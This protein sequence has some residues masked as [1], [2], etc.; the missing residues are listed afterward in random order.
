MKQFQGQAN[1]LF[2][3]LVEKVLLNPDGRLWAGDCL[4]YSF[5]QGNQET[6]ISFG[7]YSNERMPEDGD[8]ILLEPSGQGTILFEKE[9]S[10]NVLFLTERCNSRCLICPQPPREDKENLID[11]N[12]RILSLIDE[13]TKVMGITGGEPT[14]VWE[15]LMKILLTCKDDLPDTEIQL[16]T[17]GRILKS[18]EK[19]EELKANIGQAFI[20]GIPLY[21]DV[22]SLHDEQTG[23][24]GSFWDT[25]EGIFNLERLEIS[26]EIRTVINRLNYFRLSQWAEFIYRTSPFARHIA[27]MGLEPI[28]YA[29]ENL[30]KIWVDPVEYSRE[31]EKAVRFLDRRGMEV[32][33]YNHQLCTLPESLWPFC[34]KS[35]SGWKTI[36]LP[37]CGECQLKDQ[38]GGFFHSA[39]DCHSQG[40]H[41][42]SSNLR[43]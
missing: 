37:Q 38:C 30:A 25:L 16:L 35:I 22:D 3:S 34:R 10:D 43:I 17:N 20:A 27:L 1:Q 18:Y 5:S 4:I 32:S 28:G 31:L 19:T 8:I 13:D 14:L 39:I 24:K 42:I 6:G 21:G 29:R 11:L 41:P 36:Y 33:I 2:Q 9:V 7:F 26:L 12:L 15:G 23:A 40:I